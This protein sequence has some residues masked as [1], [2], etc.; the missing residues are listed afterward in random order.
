MHETETVLHADDEY[1][2]V[3]YL[4]CGAWSVERK[5]DVGACGSGGGTTQGCSEVLM[6]SRYSSSIGTCTIGLT[7]HMYQRPHPQWCISYDIKKL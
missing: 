5:D 2:P 6:H 3:A 4:K 7:Y 1:A